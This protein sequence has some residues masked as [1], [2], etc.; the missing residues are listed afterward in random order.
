MTRINTNVASLRGLRNL[1]RSNKLLDTSLSR[2]S[3]GLQ[4]NSGKDNPSGLIGSETLRSQI[5][6]IEQS[7]KNSNRANNVISTADSALG[8]ISGLLNQVRGLVQEGLN[9][10]ALSSS[11]IEA[12]QLQIDAALSA[13]NRISA[14]TSFAGD[15][16]IDGSKSFNTTVSAADSAK[17]TEFGINEA[18]FGS[19]STLSVNAKITTAAEKAE[20]RYAGGTLAGATTLEVGGSKGSQVLF[21]G[22]SSTSTNIRDAINGVSDVTGVSATIGSGLTLSTDA[23]ANTSTI[24]SNAIK[25]SA[26]V[27]GTTSGSI[28]FT[29]KRGTALQGTDATLGGVLNVT[30]TE[31]STNSNTVINSISTAGN[32]D[33]TISIEL[34]DGTGDAGGFA[35]VLAAITGNAT[36]DALVGVTNN[37]AVGT[38]AAGNTA[39][40]GGVNSETLTLTD[41]R[42]TTTSGADATLGGSLSYN[43]TAASGSSAATSISSVATDSSGNITVNVELGTDGSSVVNATLTD[44]KNAIDNNLIAGGAA[45]FIT[46]AGGGTTLAVAG[47][48]TQLTGG[49][50]GLNNDISFIDK[51]ADPSDATQLLNVEFLNA[52]SDQTL[53]VS[54]AAA[55]VLGI[56]TTT[57][58]VNLAT[59][60]AGNI[61]S[62]AKDVQ[63]L[64]NGDSTAFALFE[65]T[66]SGTG[67]EAVAAQA[68]TAVDAGSGALVLTSAN[69]GSKEFVEVN[70]LNGTFATTLADNTTAAGRDTGLDIAATINGQVAQGSGLKASIKTASLD[71]F[72]NFTSASNVANTTADITITGGGSLFQIGQQANVAG[73][74]GIG[75]DAINTARLGGVAGKLYELGSGAGK[76]LLDVGPNVQGAT[77]VDILDSSINKVSTL[78][79]RLGAIQKNVIDTNINSLG[80][81]LENISEARS[82]IIDT[83]FA[84]ETANLTKAQILSQSGISILAIANQNPQQ[85][86]SLL[87]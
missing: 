63:D 87:G 25:N 29:D 71:A 42:A 60:S 43:F 46:T 58:S 62:T 76:S 49:T 18:V 61:T 15:K 33:I 11:E 80:A 54:T 47:S 67:L 44:V 20:L 13:I 3:T 1:N 7:I 31:A 83:D 48:A 10:G 2:L 14:N 73:Q 5:T 12:N 74:I 34:G 66:A 39:L 82:Q 30:F 23:T 27:N 86:L 19:A 36:A 35:E 77:L 24:T 16:L 4:I 79:G 59:D 72:V 28:T 85:V 70:V 21:L 56:T 26:S 68:S 78:R 45:E 50:D 75:I 65:A 9:D 6:S 32:G 51:R 41:R 37:T 57:V 52:G 69:F 81:A 17:L 40:T 84:A 55:T 22:A 8:E 38:F 53:S 64:I